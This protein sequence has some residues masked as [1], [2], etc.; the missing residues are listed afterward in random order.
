MKRFTDVGYDRN[1]IIQEIGGQTGNEET[2]V[3]SENMP[4]CGA[5][6]SFWDWGLNILIHRSK[7][8]QEVIQNRQSA[9]HGCGEGDF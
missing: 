7:E 1:K 4:A 9:I 3:T 8:N 5:G 6:R 2:Q